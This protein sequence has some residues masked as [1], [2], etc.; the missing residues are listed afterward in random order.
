PDVAPAHRWRGAFPGALTVTRDGRFLYVVDQ[1]AFA[2]HVVDTTRV[3]TGTNAAGAIREPDNFPA[4]VGRVQGG[5]YPFG[6]ALSPDDRTLLVTN[7]GVF[8]YTHLRPATPAGDNNLD[9]PL[10]FPGAGY[11]DEVA[12]PRTIRIQKIDASTISGLPL[13]LQDPRGIRC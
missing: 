3:A 9:Y 8:Q 4:V 12:V 7:P 11:P 5:R 2:V 6:I 1:A 13:A 10:C